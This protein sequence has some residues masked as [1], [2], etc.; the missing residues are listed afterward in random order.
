MPPRACACQVGG[1]PGGASIGCLLLLTSET[2][3]IHLRPVRILL[4]PGV[5]RGGT[6]SE[7]PTKVPA[8]ACSIAYTICSSEH[9][10]RFIAS[11]LC[12]R[13]PK[14]ALYIVIA[15]LRF[16]RRRQSTAVSYTLAL[17]HRATVILARTKQTRS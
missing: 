5:D 3:A 16:R 6:Y 7:L 12:A 9:F 8:S 10:D 2:G 13:P 15:C 14:R 11:L 4:F 1:R 17:L